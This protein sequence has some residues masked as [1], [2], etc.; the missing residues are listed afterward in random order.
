[1]Q[2]AV[3]E[4]QDTKA[5]WNQRRQAEDKNSKQYKRLSEHYGHMGQNNVVK[6]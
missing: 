4:H 1:M 3:E 2:H 6:D 5:N